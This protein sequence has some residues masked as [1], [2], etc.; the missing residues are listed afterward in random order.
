MQI[1]G[2]LFTFAFILRFMKQLKQKSF[3][4]FSLLL[5]IACFTCPAVNVYAQS[6]HKAHRAAPK[7]VAKAA[8][9]KEAKPEEQNVDA[10]KS[11]TSSLSAAGI[12]ELFFKKYKDE[13]TEQAI[14]Y[15]FGTNKL[16]TDT[17]QISGLKKKLVLLRQ[18]VGLYL[19]KEF[20]MQK[21]AGKSLYFYSYIVKFENQP[22]RFTFMFYKPKNAWVLYHFKYDAD[23][24]T[25]LENSGR[26]K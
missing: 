2:F 22:V 23:L 14:D 9:N 10:E 20:I 4:F 18:T 11:E 21:N 12:V 7:A 8:K 17:T 6:K 15:L 16:F 25:E 19:G 26:I 13:G 1:A 5:I 24:D 3:F